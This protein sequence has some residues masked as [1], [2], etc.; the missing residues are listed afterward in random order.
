MVTGRPTTMLS[1]AEVEAYICNMSFLIL[2][3]VPIMLDVA[4]IQ[5]R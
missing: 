4:H 1:I 2:A 3:I 5:A